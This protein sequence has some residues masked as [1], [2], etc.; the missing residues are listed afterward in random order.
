MGHK[1]ESK[2][3]K[4]HQKKREKETYPTRGKMWRTKEAGRLRP[5]PTQKNY[6]RKMNKARGAGR[7]RSQLFGLQREKSSPGL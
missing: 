7:E 2:A 4:V 3:T 1:K 5:C 6:E